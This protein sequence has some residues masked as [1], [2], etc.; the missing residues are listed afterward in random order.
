VRLVHGYRQAFGLDVGRIFIA[1]E[2]LP[3][4]N[5]LTVNLYSDRVM[6]KKR[7]ENTLEF[8]HMANQRASGLP[9]LGLLNAPGEVAVSTTSS[10]TI[11]T[12]A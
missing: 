6:L 11:K 1:V 2:I 3:K 8:Y 9:E 12:Q 5:A 7:N 10:E 4:T